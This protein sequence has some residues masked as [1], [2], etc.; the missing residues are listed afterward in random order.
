M[1]MGVVVGV[2]VVDDDVVVVDVDVDVVDGFGD[3]GELKFIIG[4]AL[5]SGS[6]YGGLWLVYLAVV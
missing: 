6:M 5:S 2:V 4:A 1:L 3:A